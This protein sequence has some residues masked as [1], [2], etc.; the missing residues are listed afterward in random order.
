MHRIDNGLM[1][2]SSAF[3]RPV[4]IDDQFRRRF[5]IALLEA[6]ELDGCAAGGAGVE[7]VD[8]LVDELHR[9]GRGGDEERV[10]PQVGCDADLVAR[11]GLNSRTAGVGVGEHRGKNLG[12][13]GRVG[14][15]QRIGTNGGSRRRLPIDIG[16]Q[17][18][19]NRHRR[20]GRCQNDRV[21]AFFENNG[22]MGTDALVGGNLVRLGGLAVFILGEKKPHR[23]GDVSGV[24]VFQMERLHRRHGGGGRVFV[25]LLEHGLDGLDR[26]GR[27][28]NDYAVG[29]FVRR[30]RHFPAVQRLIDACSQEHSLGL[31]RRRRCCRRRGIAL[32]PAGR[33]LG[34]EDRQHE[35]GRRRCVRIFQ[36]DDLY[37]RRRPL[38]FVENADNLHDPFHVGRGVGHHDGVGAGVGGHVGIR[39]DQ[40]REILPELYGIDVVGGDDLRD[41]FVG[42]GNSRRIRAVVD[43]QVPLLCFFE[44]HDPQRV[45]LLDRGKPVCG[46]LLVEHFDRPLGADRLNA[47]ERHPHVD[48]RL[49]HDG[50]AIVVRQSF[51]N[52]IERHIP[53]VQRDQR[54]QGGQA[55]AWRGGVVASWVVAGWVA[56][57]C[58]DAG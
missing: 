34:P 39:P 19:G 12:G 9:L 42:G 14:K 21:G 41:Q 29:A 3:G 44:K 33:V 25:D 47:P 8:G 23:S 16:D 11:P 17:P 49:F 28:G 45:V 56:A 27:P 50:E 22:D 15:F 37:F 40:R 30:R 4:E 1:V 54:R 13:G 2:V 32:Q 24:G 7:V 55:P 46:K 18:L 20:R 57:V 26:L 58:V 5:G 48:R 35:L 53:E 51:E 38:A 6:I 43:G 31:L 36:R 52:G 10:G